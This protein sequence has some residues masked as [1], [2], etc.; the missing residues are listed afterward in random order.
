MRQKIRTTIFPYPTTLVG[1]SFFKW[2][3]YASSEA[4]CGSTNHVGKAISKN[5]WIAMTNFCRLKSV[6]YYK[7]LLRYILPDAL[8]FESRS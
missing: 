1:L 6:W 3:L 7:A 8:A 2:E 5:A 4:K